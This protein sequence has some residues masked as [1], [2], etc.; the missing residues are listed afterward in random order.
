LHTVTLALRD[1]FE[2]HRVSL[3]IGDRAVASAFQVEGGTIRIELAERIDLAAGE[4]LTVLAI[5]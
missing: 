5:S 3:Q 4:R 1:G 2:P